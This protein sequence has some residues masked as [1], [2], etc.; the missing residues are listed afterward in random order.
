MEQ[1][2][3]VSYP[4]IWE[5]E[6]EEILVLLTQFIAWD[7]E[8]IEKTGYIPTYLEKTVKLYLQNDLHKLIPESFKQGENLKIVFNGK[9]DRMDIKKEKNA[10]SLRV[11]DYKSGKYLKEN[12]MRSAIRGQKLQLPFYIIMAEHLLSEKIK[13]GH[14]PQGQI[15]I[16]EA[17]FVYVAEHTREKT[18]QTSPQTKTLNRN[19]WVNYQ[20]LYWE[21]LQEFLKI[22]REGIFPVSPSEDTQKCE[23][24]EFATT[25]RRG[26]QPLR[27][28]LEHDVRLK[29]YRE[30]IHLN[31]KNTSGK[32]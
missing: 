32:S 15:K 4:I 30:I 7:L 19:S 8:Q 31:I 27:L 29:K 18:G 10:I 14:I 3:P 12:I 20:E 5:I 26:H 13:K 25:C 2:T 23:W 21:T 11:I 17:S 24:C 28:R 6:K 1:Q 9:I 16:D 22:I